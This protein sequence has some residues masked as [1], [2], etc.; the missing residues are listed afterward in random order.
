MVILWQLYLGIFFLHFFFF[1]RNKYLTLQRTPKKIEFLCYSL[2]I[3]FYISIE[4][5][6]P[7]QAVLLS[8]SLTFA[9]AYLFRKR[10]TIWANHILRLGGQIWP[11]VQANRVKEKDGSTMLIADLVPANSTTLL[12][13]TTYVMG[14]QIFGCIDNIRSIHH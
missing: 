11:S 13:Q 3:F 10:Q 14:N 4:T 7:S 12:T 5:L 1:F 6:L 2:V 9:L 8:N